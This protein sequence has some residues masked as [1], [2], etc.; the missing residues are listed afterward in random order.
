MCQSK[1]EKEDVFV[2]Q[3][4]AGGS[5]A[6]AVDQLKEHLTSANIL[7]IFIAV[8]IT[9]VLVIILWCWY[10]HLHKKWM[11]RE[12]GRA[13]YSRRSYSWRDL[14]RGPTEQGQTERPGVRLEFPKPKGFN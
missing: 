7:M 11:R 9:L 13:Q 3:N 14:G 2:S 8:V 10:K 6:A 5:N 12:I 1:V 4:A